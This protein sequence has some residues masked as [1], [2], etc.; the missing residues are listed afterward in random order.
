MI[1]GRYQLRETLGGGGIGQ[2]FRAWDVQSQRAVAVKVFNPTRCDDDALARYAKLIAAA[3]RVGNAG[4]VLPKG[5]G[6]A[7]KNPPMIVMDSLT[8][9]DASKLRARLGRVPWMRALEL[10]GQCAEVLHAV[11][12]ATRA[13]HRDVKPSNIFIT[14]RG[15]VRVLDYGV[16]ELDVQS[17]D[18]TRVDTALGTV[19]YRAPEQLEGA[20]TDQRTDVFALGVVLY[21]LV[22]GLLPFRGNSYYE[23]ARKI[24]M[25]PAPSLAEVAPE[26]GVPVG[27]EGLIRRAL[28]KKP[29]E[30]FADLKSMGEAIA[31]VRRS[32]GVAPGAAKTASG[33]MIDPNS[34]GREIGEEDPTALLA[35]NRVP[36]A[37]PP[38]RGG[39]SLAPDRAVP[40]DRTMIVASTPTAGGGGSGLARMPA[41]RT[42]VDPSAGS[43]PRTV[44]GETTGAGPRTMIGETTGA[45]PRTVIDPGPANADRTVVHRAAVEGPANADR[46]MILDTSQQ[47]SR[48]D[49]TMILDT[50]QQPARGDTTMIL[51]DPSKPSRA[52]TTMI[53]PDPSAGPRQESTMAMPDVSE[54]PTVRRGESTM[55]LPDAGQ[56]DVPRRRP[57]GRPVEWTLQR[58]LIVVNVACGVLILVG[59]LVMWLIG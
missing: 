37:A 26:A 11:F 1:A 23:V 57:S 21:E 59:L 28:A 22:S 16:A 33:T 30:R 44:I 46:T 15:E 27:V 2:V 17:A 18:S 52:D 49:T 56:L 32:P 8:G 38:A 20:A 47:P 3:G 58:T 5:L 55:A 14:D 13:A 12:V 29:D 19:D 39:M 45:G 10:V 35:T 36:R 34:V 9:D 6:L 7:G 54:L 31:M 40:A 50:S 48:A 41:S 43:G 42:V 4:L 24:L 51:P 53:L 25:E